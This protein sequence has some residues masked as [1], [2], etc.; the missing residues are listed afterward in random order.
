M[1]L[2]IVIALLFLLKYLEVSF[3]DWLSWGWIVGLA[4]FAFLWFEFFERMLGLDKRKGDAHYEE[5]KKTRIKRSFDKK[6]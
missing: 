3:L 5:M 4:F 2:I 6:K 1:P